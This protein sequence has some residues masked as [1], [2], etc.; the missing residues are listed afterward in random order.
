[1]P[2]RRD[3]FHRHAWNANI[4]DR[5]R[6][7]IDET[8]A[9]ALA[10]T[11]NPRP[12]VLR[13]M[14]I[15]QEFVGRAGDIRHIGRVHAHARP[16]AAIREG[17]LP[18]RHQTCNGLALH[19][20]GAAL[21]LQTLKDCMRVHKAEIGEHDD[22]FAVTL[23]WI[24][25]RRIDDDRPIKPLLLLQPRMGVIP[26]GA[27]LTDREFV[28]EGLARANAGEADSG[29]AIHLEGYDQAVP[30][31]GC[32][33]VEFVGDGEPDIL[34]FAQTDQRTRNGAVDR[35]RVTAAPIHHPVGL[36]DAKRD[37]GAGQCLRLPVHAHRRRL[38]P[39]W[40]RTRKRD[41]RASKTCR[42][43]ELSSID[44]RHVLLPGSVSVSTVSIV[45]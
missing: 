29:H 39:C 12:I 10:G 27:G 19:V 21:L 24:S 37:I 1:M 22:I 20:E 45:F 8:Q 15:D 28:N 25:A 26:I 5:H 23:D 43:D 42:A 38:R 31:N 14:T 11:E 2:V 3:H 7:G 17:L 35:R 41:A 32:I 34:T 6:R 18:A 40:Q 30:V 9:H 16:L 4:E 36:C 44:L 13:P 33:L